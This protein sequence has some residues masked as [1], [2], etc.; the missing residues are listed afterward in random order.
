MDAQ[1]FIAARKQMGLSRPEMA[2]ALGLRGDHSVSAIEKIE[3][4]A[5]ISGPM[6]LAVKFLL[7]SHRAN[8]VMSEND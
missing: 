2:V 6:S 4:G 1:E 8:T 5:A 7:E 3:N